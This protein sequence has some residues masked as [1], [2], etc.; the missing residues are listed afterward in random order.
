MHVSQQNGLPCHA[1][2]TLQIGG[3]F[4]TSNL[5]GDDDSQQNGNTNQI[6]NNIQIGKTQKAITNWV[7][8]KKASKS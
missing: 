4:N 6:D 3:V 8:R 1:S 2:K 7:Q 5:T